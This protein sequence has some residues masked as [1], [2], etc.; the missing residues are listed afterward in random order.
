MKYPSRLEG[1]LR[2]IRE[3]TESWPVEKSVEEVMAWILQFENEYHDLACRVIKN[4]NVIGADDLNSALSVAY[5]KLQRHALEKGK[6][7]TKEN[8][9]Y[10][11]I[12]N[13]GKS[14]AMIAYNFRMINGLN[15]SY[16]LSKDTLVRVKEGKIENLVLIDDIIA[17]GEQS[18][19]NLIEVAKR[20]LS[21][22]IQN[23]YLMTAFGFKQGIKRLRDTEM[24]DVF[25]AVEYDENDT[26]WSLDSSF[27]EGLSHAKRQQ[28]W[29]A[30]SKYYK[31]YGYG[32]I[33]ALI[34]F[35]YNTPNCTLNMVWGSKDGWKPLFP[36]KF[37]LHNIGPD[38]YELDEIIKSENPEDV[39]AKHECS[40]FVEGK[41]EELFIQCLANKYENFGYNDVN[42]ISIGSFTSGSLISSLKRFSKKVF[43]V[44]SN[45]MAEDTGYTKSVRE[46][47]GDTRLDQMDPVMSFF[48]LAK[49]KKSE[50]FKKVI[51]KDMEENGSM[52]N[53]LFDYLE[54]KLIKKAPGIYRVENMKELLDNCA[55][56][57]KLRCFMNM[58]QAEDA[59]I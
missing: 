32:N 9:L 19:Q 10:M 37:D 16:F 44:T 34:V 46:A 18:S 5:S 30:I 20:A 17:T 48:P 40:I 7:L 58:F 13:D 45:N 14:G 41:A 55:D 54:N 42:V 51:S 8:T 59:E 22:G 52:E 3:I 28:Y 49:I 12:G 21:L 15:S 6:K 53:A 33:G 43:F 11:P 57:N 50:R 29:E 26:A 2:E 56:E 39:V 4:L 38:L 35:Y 31:G 23:I 24:A 47:M 36:R 25:S 27:Y 1:K